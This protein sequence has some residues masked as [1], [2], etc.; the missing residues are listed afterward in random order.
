M[1]T[2][3]GLIRR[4]L[5]HAAVNIRPRGDTSADEVI[6]VNANDVPTGMMPKREAHQRGIRHRAI[7]IIIGDRHGRLLLQQRAAG[8]Y[9]S[10]ELWTNTCCSHPR[11]GEDSRDAAVRRLAEEM[12]FVCPLIFLFSMQYRAEV[13]NALIEHEIVHVLGGRFDGTPDPDSFEVLAWRW[14]PLHEIACDVDARPQNYTVWFQKFRRDFFGD[15]VEFFAASGST[16]TETLR[17][18]ET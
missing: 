6:L 14:Q 10:A 9:H 12:G 7:S 18:P 3:E 13:S 15:L 16:E 11:P 8:K 17:A 2:D 1:T 4:N 5:Q